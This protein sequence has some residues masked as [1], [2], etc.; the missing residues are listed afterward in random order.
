MPKK[1]K[2]AKNYQLGKFFKKNLLKI[3]LLIILIGLIMT[4]AI[5]SNDS[6]LNDGL[7]RITK[8][9][10]TGWSKQQPEDTVMEVIPKKGEKIELIGLYDKDLYE[11]EIINVDDNSIHLQIDGLSL[12]QGEGLKAKGMNLR[13]CGLQNFV[14]TKGEIVEL[15][16]C[17][18]DMG[19]SWTLEY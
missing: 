12:K 3:V 2:V 10:W 15:N 14:M 19:V 16:T 7:L 6:N 17:S 9:P 18:M 13:G 1:N 8:S 11:L 5:K 4:S